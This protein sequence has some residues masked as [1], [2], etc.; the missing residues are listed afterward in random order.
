[1]KKP[2]YSFTLVGNP[3]TKLRPRFSKTKG[4]VRTYSTQTDDANTVAW[5]L[6]ARMEGDPPLEGPLAVSVLLTFARPKSKP[7]AAHYTVKPDLDNLVKWILDCGNNIIWKDD[8]QI[9]KIDASKIYGD[10][11]STHLTIYQID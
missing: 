1:M 8:R 2:K 4:K 11:P 3:I 10:N 6:I 9:I 7:N 5:Q